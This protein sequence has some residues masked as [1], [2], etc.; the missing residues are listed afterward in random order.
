MLYIDPMVV[1]GVIVL[2]LV[3]YQQWC[4]LQLDHDID[5]LTDKH[6]DF[7]E[8]VSKVFAAIVEVSEEMEEDTL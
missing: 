5:E 7:V 2:L 8:T 6:H 3:A 4:I 1:T